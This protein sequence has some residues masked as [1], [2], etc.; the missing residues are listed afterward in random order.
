MKKERLTKTNPLFT[1]SLIPHGNGKLLD[2]DDAESCISYRYAQFNTRAIADCPFRSKGCEAVCYATKGNHQYPSVK[3]SRSRSHEE[4]KRDDFAIRMEYTV[5]YHLNTKRF[6]GCVMI[7]RIHESGDFYSVQYLRKWI[8]IWESLENEPVLFVFYTKSFPFFL[9]LT[10][11]EKNMIRR[12][13]KA[14]KLAMN[15]SIDDT[16]SKKQL[17]AYLQMIADYPLANTYRV[18]ETAT[19]D[20]DKCDCA[21]CAK[22]G[23]CNTAK[24]GH[25]VVEIHSASNADK[26][27]YR[28]NKR[29]GK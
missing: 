5:R 21:N 2:Y 8:K 6:K 13:M 25:K 26:E 18:T 17:T 3:D 20:D 9:M 29:S 7:I 19:E 4:S 15:L 23:A 10:E 22:C 28:K 12:M 14:G 16:T 1:P 27:T 11:Q 24:G